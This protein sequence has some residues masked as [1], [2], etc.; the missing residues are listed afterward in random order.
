MVTHQGGTGHP[1]DRDINLHI[2][3]PEATDMDNDND[4]ISGSDATVALGELE[5]ESNPNE[6]LP[7]NHAK[8]TALTQE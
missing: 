7:S 1:M 8:L 3:D 2:E 6:L 5:V 4:S